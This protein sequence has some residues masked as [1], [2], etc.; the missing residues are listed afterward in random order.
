M[1]PL[2][3][4]V[5]AFIALYRRFLSPVLPRHCRFEPTCS[6]YALQAIRVHGAVRGSVLALR[7]IGRC[8][9]FS[10]GGVDR[11]PAPKGG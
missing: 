9:P 10:A 8:H 5:I 2:A 3:R 6:T 11:V 4:V 1:S 7:R